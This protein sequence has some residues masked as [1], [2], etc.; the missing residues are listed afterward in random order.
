MSEEEN[1]VADATSKFT[2]AGLGLRLVVGCPTGAGFDTTLAFR[3]EW[4]AKDER[5]IASFAKKDRYGGPAE[6]VAKVLAYFVTRWG[7]HDFTDLAMDAREAI[8]LSSY[9]CDVFQAWT[10]L[11]IETLG[12][13][14]PASIQ[15]AK[16]GHTFRMDIDLEAI[17]VEVPEDIIRTFEMRKGFTVK[18]QRETTAVIAPTRWN[19]Y[20]EMKNAASISDMK[21]A[22]IGGS[23]IG[24]T[25][26]APAMVIPQG[27]VDTLSKAD[28]ESL[29][30]F[31][32]SGNPGPDLSIE[33]KCQSC[34]QE[35]RRSV[36]W[37]YE[38]FFS[39]TSISA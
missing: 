23:V 16:C 38:V 24:Y 22:I 36:D 35:I 20:C 39:G 7:P 5:K 1:G 34:G 18:G 21:L 33:T 3:D 8:V 14:Y 28:M 10:L 15:C 17:E 25:P 12:E 13:S 19:T 26:G 30:E 31:I 11:R 4:T 6:Y 29:S 32:T 27:T 37:S 2:V 9:A